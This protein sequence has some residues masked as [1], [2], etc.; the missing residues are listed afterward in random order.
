MDKIRI[1]IA[2]LFCQA[3]SFILPVQAQNN[4]G[5]DSNRYN[6]LYSYDCMG[7]ITSLSR[8]GLLDDGNY[9]YYPY[10]GLMANST[11]HNQQRYKYN[12]KELDRMHGL[13]WYDYGA[14]WMNAAIG[15]WHMIDPLCEKYYD[16]SPYVYCNGNP[17][18][19]FDPDGRNPLKII[20]KGVFKIGKVV[21]K[22]G[23]S[24][25]NKTTTYANAF[26]V[27]VKDT[28]TVFD[29]KASTYDRLAAGVSLASEILSPVSVKDVREARNLARK[30]SYKITSNGGVSKPHGGKAHNSAIDKRIE[31]QHQVCGSYDFRKNQTQ[32]DAN[33][34]KVG[35][36]RMI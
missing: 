27:V 22:Q 26:S 34:N 13:D 7:N 15:R 24:S 25:L 35:N 8:N 18:N 36:T 4:T 29:A 1:Y 31:E 30:F 12:G 17:I 33:G 20:A 21:A 28:K 2:L 16:I 14:R 9:D 23:L 32:V 10:G 3:I 19:L 6:T 5:S 11:N